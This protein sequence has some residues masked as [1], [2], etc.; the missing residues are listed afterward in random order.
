MYKLFF[1][2]FMSSTFI[3][4]QTI[5]SV[6]VKKCYF[7]GLHEG[8]PDHGDSIITVSKYSKGTLFIDSIITIGTYANWSTDTTSKFSKKLYSYNSTGK[9]STVKEMRYDGAKWILTHL[10]SNS[11]DAK[12]NLT[13]SLYNNNSY[14]IYYSY[15]NIN[16]KTSQTQKTL[17]NNSFTN[18]SKLVWDYDASGNITREQSFYWDNNNW[19]LRIEKEYF[20]DENYFDTLIISKIGYNKERERRFFSLTGKMDST[21][22]FKFNSS[23]STWLHPNKFYYYYNAAGNKDSICSKFHK[24]TWSYNSDQ[25]ILTHK[26]YNE[27]QL[28]Q[29]SEFSYFPS[30]KLKTFYVSNYNYP[31]N[32]NG[33]YDYDN[34]GNLIL[35]MEENLGHVYG[36]RQACKYSF[37]TINVI[38]MQEEV[39]TI[40]S[41]KIYPNPTN[42]SLQINLDETATLSIFNNLG[43]LVLNQ[44]TKKDSNFIDLSPLLNGLYIL[45]IATKY[46]TESVKFLKE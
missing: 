3:N 4:A 36:S 21:Y 25:Q 10:D 26:E 7:Q 13:Y 24:K 5:D 14:E 30:G 43:Q 2:F 40:S 9:L 37:H 42:G 18:Y 17:V 15:N 38:S 31:G 44:T 45:R 35:S 1:L 23:D 19:D 29:S 16:Q 6:V 20:F 34:K 46:R 27:S 11:Y 39:P 12:G 28:S 22:I 41:F 8:V 32:S 33:Y